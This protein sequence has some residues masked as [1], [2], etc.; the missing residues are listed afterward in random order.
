MSIWCLETSILHFELSSHLNDRRQL[1]QIV[2]ACIILHNMIVEDEK[3]EYVK[4]DLDLNEVASATIVEEPKVYPKECLTFERV[5]EKHMDLHDRS[6]HLKLKDLVE[7]IYQ[8]NGPLQ[9]S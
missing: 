4:E 7:H 5:V 6:T 1:E 9:K 2:L 8:K 3:S